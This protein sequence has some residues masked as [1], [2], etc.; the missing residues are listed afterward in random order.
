M[1]KIIWLKNPAIIVAI[2]IAT[3]EKLKPT[4]PMLSLISFVLS[5][6]SFI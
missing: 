4:P 1:K 2:A 3:N 5:S 6:C